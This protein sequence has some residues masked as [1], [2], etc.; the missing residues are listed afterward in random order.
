[1]QVVCSEACVD[2]LLSSLEC[3]IVS[4]ALQ[5]SE[6]HRVAQLQN[7]TLENLTKSLSPLIGWELKSVGGEIHHLALQYDPDFKK[8]RSKY[9]TSF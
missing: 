5:L 3:L 2:S 7:K 6:G 1:M 9:D 8:N 4:R